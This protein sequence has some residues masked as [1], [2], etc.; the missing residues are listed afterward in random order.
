MPDEL[1]LVLVRHGQTDWIERG[2]LHGR[3]DSSLSPAGRLHAHRTAERLQGERFDALYTS[4]QGRALETARILGQALGLEPQPLP[5]LREVDF[6]M[7]EGWPRQLLGGDG[8]RGRL[9][10]PITRAAFALTGESPQRVASRVAAA[11]EFLVRRHPTG[12]LLL[13][14]HWS[15]LSHLAAQLL[16]GDRRSWRRFGPWE[17]CGV[18]E[19]I[20]VRAGPVPPHPDGWRW[21]AARLNDTSHLNGERSW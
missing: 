20:G 8:L 2:L 10:R 14:T 21:Q 1:R 4:P 17:A 6:G 18:S 3:V 7:L 11:V 15:V 9:L 13:L 12:R 16:G 5:E 19:L